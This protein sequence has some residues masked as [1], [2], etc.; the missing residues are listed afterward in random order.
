MRQ[1][2]CVCGACR[3]C[4]RRET[5]RRWREKHPDK[6]R[7]VA[8]SWAKENPARVKEI[9]QK[10]REKR[11][12]EKAAAQRERY[13]NF[14]WRAKALEE[15]RREG[16]RQ[17]VKWAMRFGILEKEPCCHCG[18]EAEAHHEDYDK[19]LDVVWLCRAHHGA[20]HRELR[21][22]EGDDRLIVP[23]KIQPKV[24]SS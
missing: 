14:D 11:T 16:A 23:R 8:A 12:A 10:R 17:T 6:A 20:R 7:A 5:A 22:L 9:E 13:A 4:K 21:E 1:P 19:P 18:L 24:T 15:G 3:L 2:T